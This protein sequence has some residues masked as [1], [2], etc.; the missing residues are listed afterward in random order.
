MPDIAGTTVD[1]PPPHPHVGHRSRF[2]LKRKRG[3]CES[4][5]EK[6]YRQTDD[7][8][9]G[10]RHYNWDKFDIPDH[11]DEGGE[12]NIGNPEF[13]DCICVFALMTGK[14]KTCTGETADKK[15]K[16]HYAVAEIPFSSLRNGQLRVCPRAWKCKNTTGDLYACHEI[17]REW[18]SRDYIDFVLRET[19]KYPPNEKCLVCWTK[20]NPGSG[21]EVPKSSNLIPSGKIW[22]TVPY[23]RS[24]VERAMKPRAPTTPDGPWEEPDRDQN[25]IFFWSDRR[26]DEQ[27]DWFKNQLKR[28]PEFLVIEDVRHIRRRLEILQRVPGD[29]DL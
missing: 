13:K 1:I 6:G 16:Y 17:F 23:F 7:C 18:P 9:T 11:L 5:L 3:E 28:D 14:S 4:F 12:D 15:V 8:R 24:M 22:D 21:L 19:K 27:P 10:F 2:P 26:P 29:P 20:D 25:G